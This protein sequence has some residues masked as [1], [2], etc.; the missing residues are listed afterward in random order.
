ME[1]EPPDI[2]VAEEGIP[3]ISFH[4]LNGYMVPSTLKIAGKIYGKEL[5]VLIDSGSTNNFIQTRWANHLKLPVQPSSHLRVTVGNGEVL[6]CGGECQQVPLHLGDMVFPVDLLLL[7]VFGA[8]IVLGVHWLSGLG[9]IIFDYKQ[10]W[11]EFESGGT[12][13]RLH[14]VQQPDKQDTTHTSLRRNAKNHITGEFLHISISLIDQD[15]NQISKLSTDGETT[16]PTV[17][18]EQ[19]QQL[20]TQYEDIFSFPA[21][22]P[23]VREFDHKIPL[24]PGVAPVNVRPYRYPYY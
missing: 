1:P 22:L 10:L 3:C 17:F 15:H 9:Q 5:V 20:L 18:T 6:N 11:M 7:P 13:V 4:A 8:D 19:L 16:A 23:P 14:G 12:R 24:L 2:A 21:G